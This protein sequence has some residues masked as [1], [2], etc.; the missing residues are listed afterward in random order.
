M[1]LTDP[2]HKKPLSVI[3]VAVAAM[4]V[5]VAATGRPHGSGSLALYW[6]F[7]HTGNCNTTTAGATPN[8]C[9]R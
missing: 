5:C 9:A 2:G 3:A 4:A 6:S 8:A 1:V 7:V